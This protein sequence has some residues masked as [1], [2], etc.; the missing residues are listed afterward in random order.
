[1]GLLEKIVV[2]FYLF[3]H[4]ISHLV[5]FVVPWKIAAMKEMPYKTTIMMDRVNVGDAGIRAVGVVW[6]LT[7][8]AFVAM[9]IGTFWPCASWKNWT[10]G[11][12]VF[13]TVLCLTGLPDAKIGIPA[14]LVVI[15]YILIGPK[16]G[17]LRL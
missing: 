16:I 3:A 8:L 11:V 7:G 15:A 9:A 2:A 1:V 12:A 10:L 4:G 5:G 17:L 13:S 14:N 6:L